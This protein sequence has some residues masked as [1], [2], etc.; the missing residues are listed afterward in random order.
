MSAA[1]EQPAEPTAE[2]WCLT[3]EACYSTV[4]EWAEPAVVARSLSKKVEQAVWA[5]WACAQ[6]VERSSHPQAYFL[7]LS[8]PVMV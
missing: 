4:D 7:P 1:G 2:V 5:D 6:P 8:R 3:A